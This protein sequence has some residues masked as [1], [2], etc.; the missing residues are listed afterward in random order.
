M[1]RSSEVSICCVIS[2]SDERS[3]TLCLIPDAQGRF[4]GIK[5]AESVAR[6]LTLAIHSATSPL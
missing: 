2:G 5:S 4:F 3:R 1:E 6:T